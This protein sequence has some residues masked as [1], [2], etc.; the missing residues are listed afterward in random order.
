[1]R[2]AR[3]T[4]RQVVMARKS[5]RRSQF[6]LPVSYN[7]GTLQYRAATRFTGTLGAI[8]G[9]LAVHDFPV[10]CLLLW[11]RKGGDT[12]AEHNKSS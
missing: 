3:C 8:H 1:V 5:I 6:S 12:E 9:A 7:I 4:K 10:V 11:R 2:L